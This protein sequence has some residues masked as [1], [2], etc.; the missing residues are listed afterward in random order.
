[1]KNW[2]HDWQKRKTKR[3]NHIYKL[4]LQGKSD[5][6]IARKY[7]ITRPGIGTETPLSI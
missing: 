1:M 6:E 3:N 4:H 2:K 7:K 5:A